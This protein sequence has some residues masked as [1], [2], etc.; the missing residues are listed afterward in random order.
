MNLIINIIATIIIIPWFGIVMMS[1]MM[2]VAGGFKDNVSAILMAMFLIGYPVIIFTIIKILKFRYFGWNVNYLLIGF[3]LVV[4]LIFIVYGFPQMLYNVSKGIPGSGYFI[5]ESNVYLDGDKIKDADGK[6]FKIFKEDIWYAK[7]NDHVFYHGQILKGAIAKT[8]IPVVID[9]SKNPI[10]WKDE[11]GVFY[12]GKKIES[13]NPVTFQ[14]IKGC[15]AH[16]DKNVY[17]CNLLIENADPNKFKLLN[18]NIAD[19]GVNIFIIDKQ[20][21]IPVDIESFEVIKSDNNDNYCKDKNNV[22]AVF[23][24]QMDPL[25]KVEG[26]DPSSFKPLERS[27]SVDK[28]Y[29]Y[30]LNSN[31]QKVERLTGINVK[32]FSVGYDNATKSDAND[33][34]NFLMEGEIIKK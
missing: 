5:K 31:K 8:F 11:S 24:S 32:S 1:P 22:Y 28:N 19:D 25:L 14:P 18:E 9:K 2:V 27:Y 13:A 16:D 10:F 12:L 17:F 20:S 33:G 30:F 29:V 7:D 4:G 21:K 6:S 3:S 34:V 26:A 15:Y 23:F